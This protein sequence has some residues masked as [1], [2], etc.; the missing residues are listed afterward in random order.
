MSD[1]CVLVAAGG[2]A[3]LYTL[4][5]AEVP[6]M[7]SGPNLVERQTLANPTHHAHEEHI[8][9]DL[10]RGRNRAGGAEGG[11]RG[12]GYAPG[13]AHAYDEHREQHDLEEERRFGRDISRA[14][15][16]LI[17]RQGVEH[18]VL[19]AEPRFLGVLRPLIKDS[20]PRAADLQEVGKDYLKFAPRDLHEKLAAEGY[21]PHRRKPGATAP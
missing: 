16:E 19:C 12:G 15:S 21:L 8:W 10:R 11:P 3:R 20:L 1:Y 18:I 6:E 9:T 5:P 13:E 2:G 17:D 4:E 14:L 7:E